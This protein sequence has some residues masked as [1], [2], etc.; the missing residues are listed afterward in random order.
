MI[1]RRDTCSCD[2][3]QDFS[4]CKRWFWK[5]YELQRFISA[6]LLRSH[7]THIGSPFF[8]VTPGLRRQAATRKLFVSIR[9][10]LIVTWGMCRRTWGGR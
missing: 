5:L 8:H 4:V 6:K 9:V 2:L 1:E 10:F 3:Y 7:C